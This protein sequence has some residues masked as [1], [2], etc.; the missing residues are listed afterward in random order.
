MSNTHAD[1]ADHRISIVDEDPLRARRDARELLAALIEA[2]P[3]AAL[4][5][6]GSGSTG[7]TDKGGTVSDVLGLVFGGGSLAASAIQI[8]LARVPQ[9]TIVVTRPDGTA[10]RISGK[11]ARADDA[12]IERF[13]AS[14]RSAG[15]QDG[16][17][18]E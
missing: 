18:A 12:C 11:E 17:D 9:R 3:R 1:G 10:I 6:P 14:G 13:L 15:A 8:W 7:G 2:D 5:T 4:H 16:S